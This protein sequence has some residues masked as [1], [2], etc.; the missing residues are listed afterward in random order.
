M[1]CPKNDFYFLAQKWRHEI[2]ERKKE[3]NGNNKTTNLSIGSG[4]DPGGQKTQ[5]P[6]L[7]EN[8]HTL[9]IP[10][11]ETWWSLRQDARLYAELFPGETVRP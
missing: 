11:I 10:S 2:L 8:T 6:R 9:R 4:V 1:L 3:L 7:R 5:V